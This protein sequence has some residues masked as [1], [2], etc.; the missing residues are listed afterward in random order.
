MMN[1]G[2]ESKKAMWIGL[3]LVLGTLA[4]YWPV[5]GHKFLD[6]DDDVYVTENPQVMQGLT[7]A[8]M[9]WAFTTG[10]AANW[11]PLT[12]ISHMLDVSMFGKFA[13]GHLLVNIVLHSINALLLFLLLKRM[14]K[15]LWP[16]ALVAALFAWHP[17]HVE[18]VA[19]VAERKD[20]LSTFF[21][22]LALIFYARY[23][24][25]SNIQHP[26]SNISYWLSFLFFALGLM[27][28]PML[29]TLPFVLLLLDYWPFG[30]FEGRGQRGEVEVEAKG[31]TT[32]STLAP[33][34][35]HLS[36]FR[37]LLVEKLPFFA[38]SA[39]AC[40]V[41]VIVQKAGGAIRTLEHVPVLLRV[42]NTPAA[43]LRY[44]GYTIWPENLSVLYPLPAH[45]P[46]FWGTVSL[47][48]LLAVTCE[49]FVQRARWPWLVTGWLWFLGTL[50]PVIG[51][52]QV[53]EQA[54]A[55]R[56]TYV[57]L[58]GL[59]MATAWSL[60]RWV[61]SRPSARNLAYGVSGV[62]LLACAVSTRKELG[63]WQDS[64]T[65]FGRAVAVTKD[66]WNAYNDLGIGLSSGGR[67]AEAI[68]AFQEA[69][70]IK[71]DFIKAQYNLGIDLAKTGEFAKA[72][73]H[74][75]QVVK[76]NP[77]DEKGWNNLGVVLAQQGNVTAAAEQFR[78]AIAVEPDYTN[79]YVNLG[80]ALQK[81]GQTGAAV[82]NYSRALTLDGNS[83]QA[84]D[85]LAVLYATC[86]DTEWRNLKAAV[87]LEERA[88][89][90]TGN[91]RADYLDSLAAIYAV[92]GD[93]PKAIATAEKA[94]QKAQSDGLTTLAGQIQTK[95]AA[96]RVGKTADVEGAAGFGVQK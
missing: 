5:T 61:E 47:M 13:G 65:L 11:H 4:L 93:F 9:K 25:T 57:P 63:Y 94:L 76:L 15:D 18:S 71:P 49:V 22:L 44:I 40:V 36:P 16:S 62:L 24:R 46:I 38:L 30:R 66:N 67:R 81:L 37:Q 23:V 70:R 77:N 12:W 55:D 89:E 31:Q 35:S 88:N 34:T 53:G 8:G 52:V 48:V 7:A 64:A 1:S 10:Y 82:T 14:T 58:I 84:L 2:S 21:A 17:L 50:V 90:L 74:F 68:E 3:A 42:F 54:L 75:A 26:T 43:Y 19:W 80:M 60:E 29:V 79:A 28:K 92:A 6:Y 96:Y 20:V 27:C 87:A 91:D 56:Y 95:L 86:P 45:P 33:H 41:T 83:A 59:F 72:Q 32:S 85:K 39:G 78:Q 69:V 73:E 51:L